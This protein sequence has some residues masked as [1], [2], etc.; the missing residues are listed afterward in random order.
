MSTEEK[1]QGSAPA[2]VIDPKVPELRPTSATGMSIETLLF[3]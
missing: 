2:L 3:D 1:A